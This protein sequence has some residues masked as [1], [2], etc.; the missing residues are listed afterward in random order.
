MRRHSLLYTLYLRSSLWRARRRLWIIAAGGRC[1]HCHAR[2]RLTI[3]HLTYR[4]LGHERRRDIAVLCWDCHR[5][6]HRTRSTTTR[7]DRVDARPRS[8]ALYRIA[9]LI[10]I[11]AI[12]LE[13]AGH[14]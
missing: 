14:R 1:E 10:V 12:L 7:A 5:R 11:A 3:H 8:L 2:R 9:M 6:Q 4:R 13:A